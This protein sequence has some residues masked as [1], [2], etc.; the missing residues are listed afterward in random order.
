MA[1][2]DNDVC[3]NKNFD[4]RGIDP[5]TAQITSSGQLPIGT[6]GDPAISIGVLTSPDSSIGIGYSDPDITL[7]IS[8]QVVEKTATYTAT[9]SDYFINC[10][11]NSFTVDLPTSSGITGKQYQIK[12]SGTGVITIDADG[13]ETIDG[14][15][16]QSL[17]QDES[18][19]LISNGTNWYII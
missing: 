19:T 17:I 14:E 18:M 5:P 9:S 8:N 13:T 3:W 15:L 11:A 1:G 12:N 7:K 16:T 2:F 10:T 4:F 6:G